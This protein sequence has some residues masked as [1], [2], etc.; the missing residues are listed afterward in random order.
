MA[1]RRFSK[2]AADILTIKASFFEENDALVAQSLRWAEI[3]KQQPRRVRCKNCDGILGDPLF[4]K[5][6]IDY[7]LCSTCGHLN[8]GH[9]DTAEFVKHIYTN[10]DSDY[11]DFYKSSSK[12]KFL[13][14]VSAI[15]Q[16]KV[17]FLSDCL[18]SLG[19]RPAQLSYCDVG[20]G[21][22][23]FLYALLK[24]CG[25]EQAVG[26][27]VSPR[28]VDFGNAMIGRQC[29]KLQDVTDTARIIRQC[30]A[31][32]VSMIGVL[33][34]LR[35]PRNV[36]DELSKNTKIRYLYLCLPLFSPSVYFELLNQDLYNRQLSVDHTHLYTKSS[37]DWFSKEFGLE[38]V[39]E[40]FFGTDMVDLY[41]FMLLQMRKKKC[42]A[43]MQK[44]LA[45]Q[46][47]PMIDKLQGVIDETEFC[48]E[49]HIL[50]K[51]RQK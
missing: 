11:A 39:G 15:Y 50:L 6:G 24:G 34:H 42:S 27:E 37:I 19:E 32:V 23:R 33:E 36:L 45:D 10:S 35:D 51:R 20:A 46:W 17:D 29:L 30:E 2:K 16:P 48:S 31:D 28:Q 8:G 49:I 41:R 22:G 7:I 40:W 1:I 9:E 47:I 18:I 13:E 25:C 4:G 12:E 44:H 26:Y 14:W 38:S 43:A 21:S 5:L 3:Y